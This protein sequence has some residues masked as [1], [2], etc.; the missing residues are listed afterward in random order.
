MATQEDL[1]PMEVV[2]AD[3]LSSDFTMQIGVRV[4]PHTLLPVLY[5]PPPLQAGHLMLSALGAWA[6]LSGSSDYPNPIPAGVAV[7][8]NPDGVTAGYTLG[9]PR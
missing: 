5:E 3:D 9:L 2:R 1:A 4:V 6:D 7:A 8:P